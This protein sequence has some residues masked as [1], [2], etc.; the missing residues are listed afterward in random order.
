MHILV[1]DDEPELLKMTEV[2]LRRAGYEV[3]TSRSG[4]EALRLIERNEY[5]L[6]L[7]DIRMPDL[8]GP[9]LAQ[10]MRYGNRA[11][12]VFMSGASTES[13]DALAKLGAVGFIKKPFRMT[14]LLEKVRT[15]LE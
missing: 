5:D 6:I 2:M 7:S 8:S 9:Q 11:K 1:V 10:R 13:W 15:T 4:T 14:D 3:T 12:V